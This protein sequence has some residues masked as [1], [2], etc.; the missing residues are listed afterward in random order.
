[1]VQSTCD[2]CPK[3]WILLLI[4]SL[5]HY[6]CSQV[7]AYMKD[8]SANLATLTTALLSVLS[9]PLLGL[10]KPYAGVCFGHMMLKACQH[11]TA[12]EKVC[13][14]MKEVLIKNAQDALQR[15][16]TWT[17]KSG[18]GNTEWI[19]GCEEVGLPSRRLK[20]PMKMRFPSKVVLFQETTEY[21]S[22][23][24]LCY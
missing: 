7:I 22:A 21:A 24:N 3:R 4:I 17:K 19:K 9:C 16:I 10:S 12:D 13:T 14:G 18:K 20:I 6:T 23:I 1:M 11:T 5:N 8:E 2:L 15:T